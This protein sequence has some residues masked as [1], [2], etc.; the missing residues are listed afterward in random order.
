[1]SRPG[2]VGKRSRKYKGPPYPSC[3]SIPDEDDYKSN[4]SLYTAIVLHPTLSRMGTQAA[5][6]S[7]IRFIDF[8][9]RITEDVF[10][11]FFKEILAPRIKKQ[12]RQGILESM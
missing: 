1:M 7:P 12:G 2:Q 11:S 4:L 8:E 10:L 9:Q 5:S 6:V 3:V